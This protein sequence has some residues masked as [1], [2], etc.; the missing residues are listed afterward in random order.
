MSKIWLVKHPTDQY[1]EDV[2]ALARRNDLKVYD[3]RFA[4]EFAEEFVE[5]KPPKL[6][7][8]GSKPKKEAKVKVEVKEE[9]PKPE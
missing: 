3:S 8:K 5:S 6:T 4:G 1:N 7:I 2:K 9:A